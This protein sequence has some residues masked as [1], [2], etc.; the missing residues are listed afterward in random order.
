MHLKIKQR[1]EFES[2]T[3]ALSFGVTTKKRQDRLHCTTLKEI[4]R[5]NNLCGVMGDSVAEVNREL[6]CKRSQLSKSLKSV[7]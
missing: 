3:N 7:T 2:N 6:T 5:T 1:K 4:T